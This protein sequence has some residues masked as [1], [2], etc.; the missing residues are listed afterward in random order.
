MPKKKASRY[1]HPAH[2]ALGAALPW[3]DPACNTGGVIFFCAY[4]WLQYKHHS[5][6]QLKDDSY[7]DIKE[8][9]IIYAVSAAV[10]MVMMHLGVYS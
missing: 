10:K 7:L 4:Q 2:I 8:T 9:A 6:R 5:S 3:F 1:R